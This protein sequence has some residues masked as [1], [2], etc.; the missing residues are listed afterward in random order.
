MVIFKEATP[1]HKELVQALVPLVQIY[2]GEAVS[3]KA[4]AGFVEQMATALERMEYAP[5]EIRGIDR[6]S[7]FDIIKEWMAIAPARDTAIIK[8]VFQI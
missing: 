2:K 8:S 1:R 5:K 4:V 6:G 7:F 3:T